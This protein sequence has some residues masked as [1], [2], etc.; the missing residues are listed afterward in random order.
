[1]L[2]TLRLLCG[3]LLVL[4][5]T[6]SPTAAGTITWFATN[7]VERVMTPSN[8]YVTMT[9]GTPWSLEINFDP[10]AAAK[11]IRGIPG[12]NQYP[13][14]SSSLTL[15]PYTYNSTGGTIFAQH[16]FPASACDAPVSLAGLLQFLI[17]GGQSSDPN[18]WPLDLLLV[19]FNGAPLDGSLPTMPPSQ[20]NVYLMSLGGGGPLFWRY[21]G[22]PQFELL[23]DQ[24]TPVP[25]PATLTMFGA[26]LATLIARRRKRVR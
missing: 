1:V 18:A 7:E 21:L 24:P 4:S 10:D 20:S 25:E 6:A 16:G 19:D 2:N 5:T 14:S 9:V 15:G 22:G 3:C 8:A 12:C 23:A 13:I 17:P 26:G 11:N